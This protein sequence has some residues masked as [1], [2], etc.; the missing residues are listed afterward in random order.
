MTE[1]ANDL[2]DSLSN[3]RFGLRI[4]E[5]G[6]VSEVGDGIVWISGLPSA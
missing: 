5:T 3:Y 6:T 2:P 1:I 4:A